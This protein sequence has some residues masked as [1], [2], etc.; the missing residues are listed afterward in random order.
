MIAKVMKRMNQTIKQWIAHRDDAANRG[1]GWKH[2]LLLIRPVASRLW[3]RPACAA[4]CLTLVWLA[5]SVLASAQGRDF[6][7]RYDASPQVAVIVSNASGRI[8]ITSWEQAA[9]QVDAVKMAR[10]DADIEQIQIQVMADANRVEIRTLYP[11][12]NSSWEGG[13]SVAYEIKVPRGAMLSSITAASAEIEISGPVASVIARAS[14]GNVV[15]RAITGAATL[16]STSGNV[17]AEQIGGDLRV[18]S[19]SGQVRAAQVGGAA[20]ASSTSGRVELVGITGRAS[21]HATSGPVEVR[22]VGGDV[23]ADSLSGPV[24]VTDVRGRVTAGSISA[25]VIVRKAD[26][27]VRA[28]TVSGSVEI[29]DARGRVEASAVSGGIRLINLASDDV[30]A[31]CTSGAVSF[32]GALQEGGRYEFESFNADVTLVLPATSDFRVLAKSQS[33]SIHT[34]F[35]LQLAPGTATGGQIVTGTVGRGS[36]DIRA[37]SF[38]GSVRIKKQTK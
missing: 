2:P 11:R 13:L 9:V 10:R 30:S 21:A 18:R 24:S 37:A 3:L 14:S 15:A 17:S 16:T 22:E 26:E 36:A 23:Q 7:Q 1:T 33:G 35:P 5:V 6:H 27:G 19:T 20:T 31:K 28:S 38:S 8:R 4:G 32:S 25:D 12:G 34:E 29:A